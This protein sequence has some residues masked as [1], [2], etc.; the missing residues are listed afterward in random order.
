MSIGYQMVTPKIKV[1][2]QS[3]N[4]MT[5]DFK[6]MKKYGVSLVIFHIRKT[7]PANELVWLLNPI[8]LNL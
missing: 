3:N 2:N 7:Y 8:K 4:K 1:R 6:I 5:K